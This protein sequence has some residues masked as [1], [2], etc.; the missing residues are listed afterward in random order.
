[1]P[2]EKQ[3]YNVHNNFLILSLALLNLTNCSPIFLTNLRNLIVE[4]E[5]TGKR[6]DATTQ[7]ILTLKSPGTTLPT[8]LVQKDYLPPYRQREDLQ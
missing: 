3:L 8:H 4:L 7:L 1:M 5:L 6:L 2:L